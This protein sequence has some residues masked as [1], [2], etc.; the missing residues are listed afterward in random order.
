MLRFK[1]GRLAH[2]SSRY[3][4]L[5]RL[6]FAALCVFPATSTAAA[7]GYS[8][9]QMPF[10]LTLSLN[11]SDIE[12]QGENRTILA[13][14]DRVGILVF[15]EAAPNLQFGF[16]VGSSYL[17]LDNDPVT[18]GQSLSGYYAGL[19]LRSAFGTNPQIGFH[20]NY[21]YQ[22]TDDETTAPVT[23]QPTDPPTSAVIQ[24]YTLRWD[25]WAAGV[26]GK[27]LLGQQVVLSAGWT[28]LDVDAQ[29]RAS[30][31]INSTQRMEL[32]STSQGQVGITWLVSSG[33]QVGLMLQRGSYEQVT[34]TFSQKFK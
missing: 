34:F 2:K 13:S 1:L 20:A 19:A 11:N 8:P 18:A 10:E 6:V 28:Y 3:K 30:G 7:P 22:E 9:N 26:S 5:N 27:I 16:L 23:T 31:N 21:I 12:L 33:G 32:K 14:M 4:I 15:A 24:T 17:S 29:R 25:E